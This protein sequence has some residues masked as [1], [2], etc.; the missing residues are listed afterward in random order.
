MA[1]GKSESGKGTTKKKLNRYKVTLVR[2]YKVERFIDAPDENRA[3]G[4]MYDL[5]LSH[6]AMPSLEP[7]VYVKDVELVSKGEGEPANP[8]AE[9]EAKMEAAA[10]GD[11]ELTPEEEAYLVASQ[12][13]AA[14]RQNEESRENEMCVSLSK[15]FANR[16]DDLGDMLENLKTNHGGSQMGLFD[17][18]YEQIAR[19]FEKYAMEI[20]KDESDYFERVAHSIRNN[21]AARARTEASGSGMGTISRVID[22]CRHRDGYDSALELARLLASKVTRGPETTVDAPMNAENLARIANRLNSM[23]EELG[24]VGI[25]EFLREV[26]DD[27]KVLRDF[28]DLHERTSKIEASIGE[29]MVEAL[30]AVGRPEK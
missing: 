18:A 19:E 26:R 7:K 4:I 9:E 12:R 21:V 16:F 20:Y 22:E 5:F 14:Y 29:D 24:V 1:D 25:D 2:E 6:K 10:E 28:A 13:F 11:I 23:A 30:E 17:D 3:K 8:E 27:A 15:R